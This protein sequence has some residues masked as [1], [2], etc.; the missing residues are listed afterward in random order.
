MMSMEY[1]Q[2]ALQDSKVQ[3]KLSS[4]L[5]FLPENDQSIEGLHSI[6]RS[7]ELETQL[8]GL[9]QALTSTQ[10]Q[11]LLK[12]FDLLD[13]DSAP[14]GLKALVE[15]LLRIQKSNGDSDDQDVGGDVNMAD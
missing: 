7:H 13:T 4:L 14:F 1:L 6:L 12:S 3:E 9:S 10:A 15:A 8:S 11:D 5:Q 2:D